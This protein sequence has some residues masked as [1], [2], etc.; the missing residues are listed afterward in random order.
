MDYKPK[1]KR[2]VARCNSFIY[3]VLRFALDFFLWDG[4]EEGV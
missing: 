2:G 1:K 4:G 3:K